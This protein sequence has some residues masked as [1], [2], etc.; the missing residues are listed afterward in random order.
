MVEELEG[1]VFVCAREQCDVDVRVHECPKY[2]QCI[3]WNPS[4][5]LQQYPEDKEG[6]EFW[7]SPLP[8]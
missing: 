1:Y 4:V 6:V 8:V 3:H 5:G 7:Q 2:G